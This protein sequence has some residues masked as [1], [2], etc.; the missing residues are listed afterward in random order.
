MP[1]APL[2]AVISDGYWTR[3]LI[4][5]PQSEILSYCQKEEA[6]FILDVQLS[7]SCK[8]RKKMFFFDV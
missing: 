7:S 8:I 5:R 1:G 3:K 4:R 2:I 6:E